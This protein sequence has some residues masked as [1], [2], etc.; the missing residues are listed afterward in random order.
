MSKIEHTWTEIELK[1]LK[2]NYEKTPVRKLSSIMGLSTYLIR[3]K[4][5][6]L[7]IKKRVPLTEEQKEIIKENYRYYPLNYL[8]KKINISEERIYKY[9][10]EAGIKKGKPIPQAPIKN[11]KLIMRM[12]GTPIHEKPFIHTR[13]SDADIMHM[14]A[15]SKNKY[16]H[17][18]ITI[19]IEACGKVMKEI[20]KST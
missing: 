4:A 15:L 17:E 18:E 6:E 20:Y 3:K 9:V 14:V 11:Q 5:H 19:S 8:S 10:K 7:K 13:S 12:N 1:F 2:E 16:I